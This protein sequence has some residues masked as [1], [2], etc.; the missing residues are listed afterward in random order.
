[1]PS[2]T[3]KQVIERKRKH[4]ER[5]GW[6]RGKLFILGVEYEAWKSPRSGDLVLTIK[7]YASQCKWERL[8]RGIS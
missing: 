7:A 4:L 3:A 5:T 1:M 6:K 8:K 2:E